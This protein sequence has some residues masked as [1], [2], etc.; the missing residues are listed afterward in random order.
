MKLTDVYTDSWRAVEVDEPS[1]ELE[2]NDGIVRHLETR[3]RCAR[4]AQRAAGREYRST[5]KSTDPPR[6]AWMANPELLP[7]RPPGAAR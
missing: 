3:A 2:K 5:R 7:K 1:E 4:I 6:P